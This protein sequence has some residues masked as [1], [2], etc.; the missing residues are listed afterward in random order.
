MSENQDNNLISV[1]SAPDEATA[2]IVAGLLESEGIAAT[3]ITSTT[4][5]SER[6]AIADSIE[7]MQTRQWGS[8]AVAASDIEKSLELISAYQPEENTAQTKSL[9]WE[10]GYSS[11]SLRI[12][13]AF[14]ALVFCGVGLCNL[15]GDSLLQA[16]MTFCMC[17]GSL[18]YAWYITGS[19]KY[20]PEQYQKDHKVIGQYIYVGAFALLLLG[21]RS[22]SVIP[23]SANIAAAVN[24]LAAIAFIYGTA[25]KYP[26]ATNRVR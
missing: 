24:V 4:T 19:V 12:P 5:W 17:F 10:K 25:K 22:V 7:R 18:L 23:I 6:A 20:V 2:N 26:S 16:Y 8:V 15:C 21:L 1:F 11:G 9:K 14:M 3:I 13:C